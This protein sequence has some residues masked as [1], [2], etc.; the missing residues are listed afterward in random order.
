MAGV[1]TS[2][3]GLKPAAAV[4]QSAS[5]AAAKR[6]QVAPAKD[7]RSALLG[8]AAVFAVTAASAGSARASVF[9]EYLEKSKLN[10][11][12]AKQKKVPFITDD[13]EIE[14]EGKEKFK[15]GSNV[16]WKW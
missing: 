11:D 9:D 6:V 5:P 4:P 13:L 15:C 12:L 3:V 7:R 16:F 14:C 1:N 2:V 8:L 10:K